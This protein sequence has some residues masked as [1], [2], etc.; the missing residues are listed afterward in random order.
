MFDRL[1]YFLYRTLIAKLF[2]NLSNV[3]VGL[4][5][6]TTFMFSSQWFKVGGLERMLV[7]STSIS[8]QVNCLKYG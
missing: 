3:S 4:L 1:Q 2:Q 6:K 7:K 8:L 5:R